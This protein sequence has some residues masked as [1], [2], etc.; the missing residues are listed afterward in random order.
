VDGTDHPITRNTR[1]L[2]VFWKF[3]KDQ[4]DRKWRAEADESENYI[5]AIALQN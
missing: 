5:Y 2:A 4:K 1:I 3:L